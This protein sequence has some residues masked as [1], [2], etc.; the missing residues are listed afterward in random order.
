MICTSVYIY[1]CV[2][3]SLMSDVTCNYVFADG[4][5]DGLWWPALLG[6]WLSYTGC[7]QS[8]LVMYWLMFGML[9]LS[10]TTS[11][12]FFVHG[13][14]FS[15]NGLNKVPWTSYLHA[16]L[17]IIRRDV[18]GLA[19]DSSCGVWG[20]GWTTCLCMIVHFSAHILK[21][22]L[23]CKFRVRFHIFIIISCLGSRFH[24]WN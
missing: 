10:L 19:T 16:I 8:L 12:W 5:R 4:G 3:G 23:V 24:A 17:R 15:N 6:H 14:C 18:S 1:N 9:F 7:W 22:E 13:L 11:L 21:W 20:R 2:F